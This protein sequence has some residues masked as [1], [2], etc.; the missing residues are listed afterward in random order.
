MATDEVTT[1]TSTE[2]ITCIQQNSTAHCVPHRALC[3]MPCMS[4]CRRVQCSDSP[5]V[6]KNCIEHCVHTTVRCAPCLAC[7]CAAAFSVQIHLVAQCSAFCDTMSVPLAEYANGL[8][9]GSEFQ[10]EDLE[11]NTKYTYIVWK[12]EAYIKK[13]SFACK[14]SDF[15]NQGDICNFDYTDPDQIV[16]Y[17]DQVWTRT[18]TCT[19]G[20]TWKLWEQ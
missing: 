10:V 14:V 2:Q 11:Q 18:W 6:V 19:E 5:H 4:S 9:D 13:E 17:N 3:N 7:H 15:H 8:A 1:S 12:G 20:Y 16:I